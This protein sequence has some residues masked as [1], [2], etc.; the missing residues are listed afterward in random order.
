MPPA[1]ARM[2]RSVSEGLLVVVDNERLVSG[3]DVSLDEWIEQLTN[4]DHGEWIVQEYQRF[5]SFE[6]MNLVGMLICVNDRCYQIGIIRMS[7]QKIVNI[8]HGGAF[9]RCFIPR[10]HRLAGPDGSLLKKDELHRQL[11]ELKSVDPEWNRGVYVSSSGGSGGESLYFTSDIGENQLQRRLLVDLM[12]ENAIL[13]SGDV[14]LNLFQSNNVYRSMEIFTDFCSMANCTSIPVG[15]AA[16][17]EKVLQA[18]E[19]FRSNVLMG[20]PFRLMQLAR[21]SPPDIRFEKIF[22]AG[23]PLETS[24]EKYLQ[25]IFHSS[26]C[27]GFYG[28]GRDRRVRLSIERLGR[29][30]SLSLSEES[31]GDRNHR[32]RNH[33]D[34]SRSSTQSTGSLSNG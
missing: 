23:E 13:S 18:I 21:S 3:E 22:F 16:T 17:D 2:S 10:E 27:L 15:A 14:C 31:R 30:E 9:A 5:A 26:F 12:L 7:S 1:K 8:C 28:V 29:D 32:R 19:Y 34:E 24:K 11:L 33:R 20:T 4:V 25:G 6:S